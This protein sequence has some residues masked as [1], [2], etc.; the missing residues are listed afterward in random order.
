MGPVLSEPVADDPA[1]RHRIPAIDRMMDVLDVLLQRPG[2]ATLKDLVEAVHV[3]RS[4]IYRILN[5]LETHEVVRHAPGGL[6]R[7]GP[8]LLQFSAGLA[9]EASGYDLATLATPHLQRLSRTTGESSRV[10]V[11][12]KGQTLVLATAQGTREFS[13]TAVAGQHLPVHAGAASKVLLA[14]LSKAERAAVLEGALTIYTGQTIVDAAKLERECDKIARQGWSED[15]GEFSPNVNA[16]GAPVHDHT[17]R[18]IAA[19]SVTFLAGKTDAERDAIR[20]HVIAGAEAISAEI[21]ALAP[22]APIAGMPVG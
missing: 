20:L 13:L 11:L 17:N 3:P 15:R 2:G 18:V 12:D 14:G 21:L 7:L 1:S 19:I 10:A 5:S 22:A 6:Y 16:F 9:T 8:R 4:T